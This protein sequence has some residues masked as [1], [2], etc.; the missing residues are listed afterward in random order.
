MLRA[1]L[2]SGRIDEAVGAMMAH[3]R[4]DFPR[5]WDPPPH[6]HDA[7]PHLLDLTDAIL[8]A[9]AP[10]WVLSLF[11]WKVR[12]LLHNGALLD[13][14]G[15][16]DEEFDRYVRV[17]EAAPDGAALVWEKRGHLNAMWP[18]GSEWRRRR[19]QEIQRLAEEDGKARGDHDP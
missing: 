1:M 5:Q 18:G 2:Y 11:S 16:S 14:E 17:L 19:I 4:N 12:G 10:P 6:P 9:H 3:E 13:P 15:M 7:T 8:D